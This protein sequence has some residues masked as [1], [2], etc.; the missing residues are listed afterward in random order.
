MLLCRKVLK[1]RFN[2]RDLI[3]Q[4]CS[5]GTNIYVEKACVPKMSMRHTW[6]DP[7]FQLRRHLPAEGLPIHARMPIPRSNSHG[8][9]QPA[10]RS[11]Y[12]V[13]NDFSRTGKYLDNKKKR[14]RQRAISSFYYLIISSS[15]VKPEWMTGYILPCNV[16]SPL[17]SGANDRVY[18]S[19]LNSYAPHHKYPWSPWREQPSYCWR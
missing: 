3:N 19:A 13:S 7:P 8:R 16:S 5:A 15:F 6:V 17:Q 9:W 12:P 18:A 2:I 4:C 10:H 1:K 11:I 14:W